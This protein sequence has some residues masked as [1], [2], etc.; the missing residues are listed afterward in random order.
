MEN[1]G[2]WKYQ[3]LGGDC[4]CGLAMLVPARHSE[5]GLFVFACGIGLY[6]LILCPPQ[7][8]RLQRRVGKKPYLP[9]QNLR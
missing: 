7:V 6:V 5:I 8:N 1:T 3:P 2:R 9:L 4:F